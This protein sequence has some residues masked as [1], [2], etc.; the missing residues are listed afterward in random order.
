MPCVYRSALSWHIVFKYAYCM[1]F[2]LRQALS[3]HMMN[4]IP[5]A[6]L[7]LMAFPI[8]AYGDLRCLLHGFRLETCPV[9]AYGD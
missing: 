8:M 4:E 2:V 7:C 1:A 3:W 6:D 5:N 9:M